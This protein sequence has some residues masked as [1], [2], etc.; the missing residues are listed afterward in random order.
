MMR[1]ALTAILIFICLATEYAFGQACV[2]SDNGDTVEAFSAIIDT[3]NNTVEVTLGNDSKD[4]AANVTVTVAVTY[5]NSLY[6]G[7]KTATTEYSG[8]TQVAPQST[9]KLTL[10]ISESYNNDKNYKAESVKVVS[11]SGRKCVLSSP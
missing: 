1:Q 7:G 9:Q 11:V 4:I 10:S 3:R 5:R 2:I 6:V 8:K